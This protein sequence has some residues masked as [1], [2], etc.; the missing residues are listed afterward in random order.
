VS[1]CKSNVEDWAELVA[2]IYE[3]AVDNNAWVRIASILSAAFASE[4][5]VLWSVADGCVIPENHTLPIMAESQYLSY[6]HRVDVWFAATGGKPELKTKLNTDVL[7]ERA[8]L[9]SEFFVDFCRHYGLYHAALA[10]FPIAPNHVGCVNIMRPHSGRAFR[11]S[12]RRRLDTLLPHIQRALQIRYRLRQQGILGV[13]FAALDSLTF[14][15]LVC[16]GRGHVLFANSAAEAQATARK[17]LGLGSRG[18]GL[19]AYVI[20][21]GHRLTGLIV[22][23]SHGGPGGGLRLTAPDGNVL[24]VLV[25]PLPRRFA[26]YDVNQKL[27][28]LA[29]RNATVHSN[30]TATTLSALF[31][32]TRAEANLAFGLASGSSLLDSMRERTVTES[33]LRT[34][35]T[36]VLR[37][38]ECRNQRDLLRLLGQLPPVTYSSETMLSSS[39]DAVTP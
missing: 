16:D 8:M 14:S 37:K 26:E 19:S 38:T 24:L 22:N 7:S 15:A 36:S 21:E 2:A 18:R 35:L 13:G 25:A 30:F 31:K 29:Y 20:D 3:A 33:T 4:N 5:A 28:L 17:G 39:R 12:D 27:V 32:L 6:Y 34:Q 1:R 11:D 10:S 9:N 23:A